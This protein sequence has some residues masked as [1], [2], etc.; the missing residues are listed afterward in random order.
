MYG[1][2]PAPRRPR[3]A[4]AVSGRGAA[5]WPSKGRGPGIG[6]GSTRRSCR[7]ASNRRGRARVVVS[8]PHRVGTH[9]ATDVPRRRALV[10]P[11]RGVKTLD[12]VF[13]YTRKSGCAAVSTWN[14]WHCKEKPQYQNSIKN[15]HDKQLPHQPDGSR[16]DQT[17][18]PMMSSLSRICHRKT[19]KTWTAEAHRRKGHYVAHCSS[20]AHHTRALPRSTSHLRHKHGEASR[21]V[22]RRLR[23]APAPFART[24]RPTWILKSEATHRGLFPNQ[25]PPVFHTRIADHPPI[26]SSA[27]CRLRSSL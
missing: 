3:R 2:R 12:R 19:Q 9:E 15:Q 4:R 6:A 1:R 27:N 7:R 16:E 23:S 22:L 8:C 13:C 24:R 20:A 18:T 11:S 10:A 26:H 25:R 21:H 14:A 17:K 5:R